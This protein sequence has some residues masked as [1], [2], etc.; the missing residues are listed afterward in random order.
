MEESGFITEGAE[1]G[2]AGP[3][4]LFLGVL[5]DCPDSLQSQ[6]GNG[7][8][9]VPFLSGASSAAHWLRLLV[10]DS[11]RLVIA[12]VPTVL[13]LN[14]VPT[15]LISPQACAAMLKSLISSNLR[16][17][18]NLRPNLRN[19]GGNEEINVLCIR[20]L[21]SENMVFPVTQRSRLVF[22]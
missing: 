4:Y 1:R 12:H 14:H 2:A 15:L 13:C 3:G 22:I 7:S 9:L 11:P 6:P 20:S 17:P 21:A 8:E 5:R 10:H 16:S 19:R 18:A